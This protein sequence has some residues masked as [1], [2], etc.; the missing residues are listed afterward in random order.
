MFINIVAY[1]NVT[2]VF[3][4]LEALLAK[5]QYTLVLHIVFVI[6]TYHPWF[7]QEVVYGREWIHAWYT[8][9]LQ[10]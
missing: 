8:T 10:A 5:L 3:M 4:E 9:I 7:I 2:K 6:D 1:L